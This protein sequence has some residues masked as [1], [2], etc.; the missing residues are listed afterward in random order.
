MLTFLL[1]GRL[2]GARLMAA[3][4]TLLFEDIEVFDLFEEVEL[5]LVHVEGR[6]GLGPFWVGH[7]KKQYYTE[8]LKWKY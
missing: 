7:R 4:V 5:V 2:V 8:T 6:G 3:D 1:K